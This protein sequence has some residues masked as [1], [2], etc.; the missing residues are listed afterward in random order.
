[1]T[2][3]KPIVDSDNKYLISDAGQVWSNVKNCMLKTPLNK[4]G[5]PHFCGFIKGKQ[6][7]M[8]VHNEL[9]KAFVGPRSPGMQI[10]HLDGNKENNTL[11]NLQYGT[12][13]ENCNDRFLHG[14]MPLGEQNCRAKFTNAEVIEIK[15][16]LNAGEKPGELSKEYGRK[17][18]GIAYRSSWKHIGPELINDYGPVDKELML[19]LIQTGANI[20][21][22]AQ[23]LGLTHGALSVGLKKNG[24]SVRQLRKKYHLNKSVTLA[25]LQHIIQ[26]HKLT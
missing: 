2:Q 22:A 18:N 26:Q 23:A 21:L 14:T 1:M 16:R 19:K 10:R 24:M 3:W 4:A 11:V 6:K 9:M 8:K 12:P 20:S 25:Q 17:V 13:L 7:T 5:Y 15:N